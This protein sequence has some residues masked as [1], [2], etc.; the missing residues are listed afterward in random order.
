MT[1]EMPQEMPKVL[2]TNNTEK[3]KGVNKKTER[4]AIKFEKKEQK[5]LPL[6]A[7]NINLPYQQTRKVES[8]I[9]KIIRKFDATKLKVLLISFRNN[10]YNVLDG[11]HRILAVK[12]L[13][14]MGR[15]E[16][17]KIS[18]DYMLDCLIYYGL[19]EEDEARIFAEQQD[20]TKRLSAIDI[21]TGEF[22]AN[23]AE[24][25]HLIETLDIFEL[26]LSNSAGLGC[27]NCGSKIKS[28]HEGL[29]AEDFAEVL[30]IITQAWKR[31]KDSLRGEI[32]GGLYEFY[33][34]YAKDPSPKVVVDINRL[35]DVLRREAPIS[36]VRQGKVYTDIKGDKKFARVIWCLYNQ[37]LGKDR[38]L[39]SRF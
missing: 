16:V 6:K 35:I 32:L 1:Q 39:P 15:L 25:R 22:Y 18:G 23:Y 7:L 10:Q 4:P 17:D 29:S 11:K 31:E 27:I 28:I 12:Q 34:E 5:Q 26:S 19:T 21:T 36:I 13:K 9:R 8:T 20:N 3:T 14:D 2:K 33:I 37:N 30:R 38:K 24:A